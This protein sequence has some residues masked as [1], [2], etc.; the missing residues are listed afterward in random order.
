MPFAAGHGGS[1]VSITGYLIQLVRANLRR[2]VVSN[3]HPADVGVFIGPADD[4]QPL[5]LSPLHAALQVCVCVCACVF[6]CC[7]HVCVCLC[8]RSE[9]AA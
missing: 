1:Y 6:V 8:C 2:L 9:C 4:G 3:V 5:T 7:V